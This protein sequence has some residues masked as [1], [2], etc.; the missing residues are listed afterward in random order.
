MAYTFKITNKLLIEIELLYKLRVIKP[1]EQ[2]P[3]QILQALYLNAFN[4]VS[5]E[6]TD[7]KRN[8]YWAILPSTSEDM[9]DVI[10]LG[11]KKHL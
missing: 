10:A 4:R 5:L 3:E 1:S 6:Q 2:S 7:I 11:R 9:Q 8:F